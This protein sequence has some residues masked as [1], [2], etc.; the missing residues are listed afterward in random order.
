[1]KGRS[2]GSFQRTV[3]LSEKVNPSKT[4]ASYREGVL[5][6]TMHKSEKVKAKN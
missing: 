6:I 2:S 3:P 4:K 5:T 1:M